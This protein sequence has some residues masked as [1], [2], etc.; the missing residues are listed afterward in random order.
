MNGLD[1]ITEKIA[2]DAKEEAKKYYENADITVA[3][4]KSEA[5]DR[6]M[7][8][9][10][11]YAERAEK[12]SAECLERAESSAES[13]Y[14]GAILEKK[15]EMV[16]LAFSSAAE[17]IRSLSKREYVDFMTPAVIS[18]VRERKAAKEKISELYG[19][20]E[21]EL[22]CTYELIF[23]EKDKK[24]GAAKE[25]FEKASLQLADVDGFVLSKKRA[26]IDGGFILRC[27]DV[28]INCSVDFMVA[29]AR[30]KCE[31]KVIE[32]LFS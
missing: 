19:A 11:E 30:E 20:D 29:E 16:E 4:L 22:D 6:M 25:I 13:I 12:M 18:T 28:E 23:S 21:A 5:I 14:R 32:K 1:K 27:N 26:D 3:H 24:S 7:R 9:E 2:R 8:M 17:K 10:K 15:A 31:K